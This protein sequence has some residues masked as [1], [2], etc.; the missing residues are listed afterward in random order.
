MHGS[1]SI[2]LLAGSISLAASTGEAAEKDFDPCSLLTKSEIESVQGELVTATKA[3]RPERGRFAVSQCFYSLPT[4]SKSISLEVTRPRADEREKPEDQWKAMFRGA[5]AK[6]S[7]REEEREA[8]AREPKGGNRE[9]E[10][11]SEKKSSPPRKIGG[12]GDEAYWVGPAIVGGL[13]VRKGD[14][15]F[16]VSVG[17]PEREVVKIEK[18]KKLGRKAV[19]RL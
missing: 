17:G 4:F 9:E 6:N 3:S 5:P 14:S 2:V 13:Y 10:E 18:L 11:E 8:R 15:Y 7:E 12:V 1:L 16:R 19:R